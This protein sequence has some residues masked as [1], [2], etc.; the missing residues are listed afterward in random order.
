MSRARSFAITAACL[1][2]VA[3]VAQA[4]AQEQWE[5]QMAEAIDAGLPVWDTDGD[6]KLSNDELRKRTQ[7]VQQKRDAA[8]MA[9]TSTAGT[10]TFKMMLGDFSAD[11]DADGRLSL[12]EIMT[13][14][15][16]LQQETKEKGGGNTTDAFREKMARFK[17]LKPYH[18]D[19]PEEEWV[20]R[21]IRIDEEGV[22]FKF[23]WADADG[24]GSLDEAEFTRFKN[25]TA[26][27]W[28]GN[29][30]RAQAKKDV[31]DADTDGDG[32]LSVQEYVK[33]NADQEQYFSSE[34]DLNQDGW[35]TVEEFTALY[36][37]QGSVQDHV[38]QMLHE[39][40]DQDGDGH[41]SYEEIKSKAS[42]LGW[43]LHVH[44]DEL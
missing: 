3:A 10:E 40:Y 19:N 35:A 31:S 11:R 8:E 37:R 7:E 28:R 25:P 20:K 17:F 44:H 36:M 22:V 38:Q 24:N 16:E 29:Y 15:S 26:P 12:K 41:L 39:S 9:R 32:V 5:R 13:V 18:Y 33:V 27:E 21:A 1:V 23:G 14:R 2:A 42:Q 34:I 30:Q 43:M 4:S 6:G